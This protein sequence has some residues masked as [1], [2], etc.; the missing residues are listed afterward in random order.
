MTS[1]IAKHV[2]LVDQSSTF[3]VIALGNRSSD[4]GK[5]G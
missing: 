3:N 2:Q 5:L 1:I 4:S